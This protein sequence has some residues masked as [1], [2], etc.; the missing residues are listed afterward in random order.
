MNVNAFAKELFTEVNGKAP[1]SIEIAETDLQG[2]HDV[3]QNFKWPAKQT[4]EESLVQALKRQVKERPNDS[5]FDKVYL[6]PQQMRTFKIKYVNEQ[7][8]LVQTNPKLR[9]RIILKR[10]DSNSLMR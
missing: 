2:V 4:G 5:R 3:H 9:N 8:A 1:N 6:G 10:I 7:K